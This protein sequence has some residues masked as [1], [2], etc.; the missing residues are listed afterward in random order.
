M[1]LISYTF[2]SLGAVAYCVISSYVYANIR[3]FNHK[4]YVRIYTLRS[5]SLTVEMSWLG[6]GHEPRLWQ[7]IFPD[8]NLHV[9]NQQ[10]VL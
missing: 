8:K 3:T 7:V 2:P 5:I 10:S 6:A 4:V 9:H 1:L